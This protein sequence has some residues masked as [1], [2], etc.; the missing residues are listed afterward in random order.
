[1]VTEVGL[2]KIDADT[3]ISLP[4]DYNDLRDLLPRAA[5]HSSRNRSTSNTTYTRDLPD[6]FRMSSI[7]FRMASSSCSI[8]M[9]SP[10][11]CGKSTWVV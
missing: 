1:M 11:G 7:C 9:G 3:H 6:A 4:V 2:R 10:K 5:R 8:S